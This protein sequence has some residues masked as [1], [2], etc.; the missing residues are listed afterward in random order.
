MFSIALIV[1][2]EVFEIA[3]IVGILMAATKG[4]AR[5]TQWVGIGIFLGS[6]G[7]ALIAFFADTISQAAE[8]MGQEMLNAII[9]LIAAGLIGWTTLWM[10]RHGRQLSQEFNQIGRDVIKGSKPVYTL[11]VVVAL[12]VL[13]E[14]AEI[15]MFTYS[16]FVT[17]G[18]VLQLAAGGFLGMCGGIAVGVILYFGLMKIPVK[19]IF[20]VTS[21]LLVFLVAGMAAQAFGFLTAAG[22]VPEI[23]PVVWDTSRILSNGSFTGKILHTLVGYTDRPSGIQILVYFITIGGLAVILKMYAQSPVQQAKKCAALIM[24][25][26][27]LIFGTTKPAYAVLKVYDPYV[28]KGEWELE[29][30]G[31]VDFDNNATKDN[32][33]K[34]KYAL[35]YGVTDWWFTEVYGEWEKERNDNGEDLDFAFTEV[36]WENKFQ[37]T[38]PGE[39]PVDVGFLVEYEISAED[40]HA[41][42]LEWKIL[43]DKTIGKV[44]NIAN[45]SFEH[46][47]GGGHTNETGAGFAWSSR[48]R[49][50][51]RFEPGF[52]YH[53]DF[54]GLNEGKTFDE[55]THR[56]GPALYGKLGKH[57]KYDVGYL[58]GLSDAAPQGTF[59]WILEFEQRF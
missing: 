31:S 32:L 36:E 13:R 12:S 19:Q 6:I 18:N 5:R 43:L 10:T 16:A 48:Y 25:G 27:G 47:V 59:K 15:V 41:D 28:E 29:A 37:L 17:G 39:Y 20:T 3:L 23:I 38:E 4:L 56:M 9:L 54:G 7:S 8:G 52:E 57:M 35:G 26:L 50:D 46:Q 11:A 33:Q 49:L 44:G 1:F 34:Q 58:F 2:R 40:K 24:I 30:R 22:K 45:I 55:Q 42:N 51:P 21:W 53:A 14:G